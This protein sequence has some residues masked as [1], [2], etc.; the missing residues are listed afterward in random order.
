MRHRRR[1][2]AL[3]TAAAAAVLALQGPFAGLAA[4]PQFAYDADTWAK[5]QDNVMEYSELPYLVQEDDLSG[6]AR[7]KEC[8]GSAG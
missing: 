7:H 5:L 8:E 4:S 1:K 2:T 3:L 6:R